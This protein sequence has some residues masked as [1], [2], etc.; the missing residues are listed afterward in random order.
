VAGRPAKTGKRSDARWLAERAAALVSH[1]WSPESAKVSGVLSPRLLTTT[2]P[3][4]RILAP[5]VVM[6]LLF[7]VA[8]NALGPSRQIHVLALPLLGILLWNVAMLVLILLR[9]FLPVPAGA[10][11]L[12]NRLRGLAERAIRH[13]T[14]NASEGN[15]AGREQMAEHSDPTGRIV[16]RYLRTWSPASA[17]LATARVRRALHA[18]SLAVTAGVIAG[19]Y[20]RGLGFAYQVTWEST[21]LSTQTVQWL[22]DMVLAPASALTSIGVPSVAAIAASG[23]GAAEVA[24]SAA[25]W[26]HLWAATAAWVVGVPRLLLLTVAA[27][28]CRARARRVAIELPATYVRRLLS[29]ADPQ[30]RR[31]DV[32]IYSYQASP[33]ATTALKALLLDV[34]GAR[35]QVRLRSLGYGELPDDGSPGPGTALDPS[36][37]CR[38]VLFSLAQTPEVEVHGELVAGLANSLGD[39]QALV[40]AIDASA[41]RKRLG[42]G[43]E[44]RVEERQRAWNRIFHHLE[45]TPLHVD[46]EGL[47]AETEQVLKAAWPT[48]ILDAL[49]RVS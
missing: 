21:F 48:G 9:R 6:G 37:R 17:P 26:I 47:D 27:W 28:Q 40:V 19:M 23:A 5:V 24:A 36:V 1:V 7:G 8:T 29:A 20:L 35:A 15:S 3:V 34:F 43:G 38:L 45:I 30:A 25:P 42:D 41:Y 44:A 10:P 11:R 16:A 2:D 14:R 31:I 13:T 4:R 32:L 39:G 12:A 18:G 22:L 46:L 49:R 33:T